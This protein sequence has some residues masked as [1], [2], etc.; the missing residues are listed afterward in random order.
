MTDARRLVDRLWSFCHV[1]RD[2]GVGAVE[3]V[4]QL[5]Y[6]LF[7]KMAEERGADVG[8]RRLRSTPAVYQDLLDELAGRPGAL[9]TVYSR[10]RNRIQDPAKLR[11]LIVLI[12]R[13]HWT[14][15]GADV[16]GAAYEELLSRGAEDVKSG[17]GQ[18][19][20]PRPV[21]QA[22]VACVRPTPADTV[23]D[24]A[25][26]TGG[27]LLE[28]ARTATSVAGV[29]LVD[30]TAR[31]AAMNLL[32]HGIG[33]PDGPSPVEVGDAL[34]ADPGR[35]YSVVLSNPPFGRR[36]GERAPA[37][38]DF[39]AAT[40]NKQLN[41]VQHIATILDTGGRAAVVVPDNVLFEGGA[42]ETVRRRLLCDFDL[43]T[44]LR[45]PTGIFYAQG[46]KANVLFFDR[47]PPSGVLWV[48]DLR[49]GV[50]FTLKQDPLRREHLD[51]FVAAYRPGEPR[52]SRV[53]GA[54]FRPFGHAALLARERTDL[55]LTWT[56]EPGES[57]E[58]GESGESSGDGGQEPQ[59]LA[60]AIVA[61]LTAALREFEA[62][63][64]ELEPGGG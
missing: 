56:G 2:D 57:G 14:G 50:H 47:T 15:S 54:R 60:R 64:A 4:E 51:G 35:R 58:N 30:G 39:T 16:A 19:F 6:L 18:Y 53:P 61:D 1:L 32:L 28:A 26:G 59:R 8:W 44:L 24:P 45:L 17:A 25:A 46:V 42:G 62:V 49:A 9:G 27:F 13:E 22:M 37:R 41:F 38:A 63:A 3:Y 55:D 31:L 52:T 11:R 36:A 23:V 34:A 20:T 5:T 29:E 33:T 12:D 21:V 43:H 40:A 10:A 48:Y 7:L